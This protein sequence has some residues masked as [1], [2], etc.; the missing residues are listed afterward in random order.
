MNNAGLMAI[1]Q[2]Q[3]ADGFEMQLGTNH[4]GHFALTG[5]L[6]E[7]LI[8]TPSSRIISITS[9]AA[10]TGRINF[11]DLMSEKSYSRWL[12]YGQSKLANMLFGL[13]LQRKLSATGANTISVL[14]HPGFSSTNLQAGPAEDGGIVG[15]LT[16]NILR[17][18]CQSQSQGALPQLYA[19]TQNDVRGGYYYGPSGVM[20]MRGKPKRVQLPR[21]GKNKQAAEQLWLESVVLTGVDYNA[22]NVKTSKQS[23]PISAI[24]P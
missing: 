20:E 2:K 24:S 22:L 8:N 5:G 6:I 15:R 7:M 12:A 9:L 16:E 17:P 11:K 18:M 23:R 13:E 19:A 3:T 14:A 10:N 4:L 21:A 1:P